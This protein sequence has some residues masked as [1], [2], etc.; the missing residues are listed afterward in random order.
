MLKN[1]LFMSAFALLAL[2]S[3]ANAVVDITFTNPTHG[4]I[5]YA[6]DT[7]YVKWYVPKRGKLSWKP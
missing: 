3:A 7:I 1:A 5:F 6:G 4:D 2:I